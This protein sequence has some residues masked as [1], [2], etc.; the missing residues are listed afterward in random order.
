MTRASPALER[1]VERVTARTRDWVERFVVGLGLCPFARAPLE[2]DALEL[3]VCLDDDPAELLVALDSTMQAVLDHPRTIE[4]ALLVHPNCLQEF[5]AYN[6]F[7][8]RVDALLELRGHVGVLQ[9]ASFHPSYRFADAP[10]DD[11]A[12]TT[13]R[14]PYPMLHVLREASVTAAVEGHPDVSGI[15]TRNVELLRSMSAE[16]LHGFLEPE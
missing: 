15:P 12:N 7:L 4:T 9:V 3:R 6:A 10:A 8:D 5:E 1:D 16:K 11:P 14:S 2:A 13:N